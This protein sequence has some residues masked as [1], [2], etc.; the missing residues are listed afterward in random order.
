M[1]LSSVNPGGNLP[2]D[3]EL[4]FHS[5]QFFFENGNK[6]DR[7]DRVAVILRIFF[8]FDFDRKCFLSES[9]VWTLWGNLPKDWEPV[10]TRVLLRV[11]HPKIGWPVDNKK[12]TMIFLGILEIAEHRGRDPHRPVHR[13]HSTTAA[14]QH[15]G[16]PSDDF[17]CIIRFLNKNKKTN[18]KSKDKH[19][20]TATNRKW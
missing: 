14:E 7:V 6:R 2:K 13:R 5:F 15:A 11:N 9:Q 19:T 17:D 18:E 4:V 8:R 12:K 3:R 16:S 10:S 1:S 20:H